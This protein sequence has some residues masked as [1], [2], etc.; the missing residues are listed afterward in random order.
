MWPCA[1]LDGMS[2]E[3]KYNTIRNLGTIYEWARLVFGPFANQ[4]LA[5][6]GRRA[7]SVVLDKTKGK[8][9][10]T[11]GNRNIITSLYVQ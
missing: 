8:P 3:W 11:V 1:S 9:P 6:R 2:D 7:I 10:A 5:E 4:V